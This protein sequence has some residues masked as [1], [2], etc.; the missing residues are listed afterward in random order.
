MAN[1]SRKHHYVPQSL[2]RNFSINNERR[3]VFV[4]DKL[5]G[6]VFPSSIG[7]AGSERDF[8]RANLDGVDL[9][10]EPVFQRFDDLLATLV[11]R[12]VQSLSLS[13]L[14]AEQSNGL[15]I[16]AACQL[17]RTKLFRTS[18]VEVSRQLSE[19]V[20]DLGLPASAPLTDND[21]R[22]IALEQLVR[23]EEL[24]ELIAQ[25]DVALLVSRESNLWISDNPVVLH[26]TFPYGRRALMAPGIEIYYPL[27]N[28]ICLGFFC[29]SIREMLSEALDPLH[30]RPGPRN[31]FLI[32]LH[33]CLNSGLTIEI[34]PSYATY[35][36]SLQIEQSSRFL[37]GNENHFEMARRVV[38]NDPQLSEV[39]S[40]MTMG[41]SPVAPAPELPP[42]TWLVVEV[43]HLHHCL[44]ITLIDNGSGFIDFR[45][46]DSVK[47]TIIEQGAPFD[48]VTVF[49]NGNGVRGMRNVVFR[50]VEQGGEP[51]VRIEHTDP[52]LNAIL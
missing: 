33:G 42:G 51:F 34:P 30:P 14:S 8:N 11:T 22:R 2:L 26:N 50:R 10:F 5:S 13:D 23:L 35:L 41:Q 7:D 20:R 16:L 48:S 37:Y 32:L 52:T 12:I 31:P 1:E 15:A 40:L 47:L 36:N 29:P 45:T 18:P 49:E 39:K 44:K 46:T 3:Q 6:R 43:G 21:T 28:N 25:K 24:A 38:N 19:W 27:A 9:N 17:V 4:F